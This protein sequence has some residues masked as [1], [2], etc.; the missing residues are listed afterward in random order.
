MI[1]LSKVIQDLREEISLAVAAG[2]G[3]AIQFELGTIVLEAHVELR[4]DVEAKGKVRFWV[5]EASTG[6]AVNRTSLHKV[7]I[8]L[9]P[10][11]VDPADP[12]GTRVPTQVAG[13]GVPGEGRPQR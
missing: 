2:A 13:D 11:V 1:E 7:T 8:P 4:L 3:E 5:A 12:T 6:T 10:T 9:T